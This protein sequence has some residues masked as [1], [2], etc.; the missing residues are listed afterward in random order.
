MSAHTYDPRC[1]CGECYAHERE[2]RKRVSE[3]KRVEA[4]PRWYTDTITEV[5]TCEQPSTPNRRRNS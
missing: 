3:D 4:R 1:C 2:L 5:T